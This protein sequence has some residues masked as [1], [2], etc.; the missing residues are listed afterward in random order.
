MTAHTATADPFEGTPY[1]GVKVIGRGGMG[2][3]WKA[4][5]RTLGHFVVAKFMHDRLAANEQAVER[6]RLEAQALAQI[7]HPNVVRVLDYGITAAGAPY[8]AME[9]LDGQPLNKEAFKRVAMPWR[10]AADITLQSLAGLAAAHECGVIH[11]D[12]KPGNIFYCAP[13]NGRRVVKVLDFGI[14]KVV[15]EEASRAKPIAHPTKTGTVL[16]TPKYMAPEQ[17]GGKVDERTD[18]YAI[19]MIFYE[20]LAG[21]GPFDD[22]VNVNQLVMKQMVQVPDPPSDYSPEDIPNALDAVVLK[23]LE[24]RPEDRFSSAA[25][26]AESIASLLRH[27]PVSSPEVAAASPPEPHYDSTAA[28][29]PLDAPVRPKK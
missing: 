20:L 10:E 22:A 23:A 24:K 12:I 17:I 4:Q 29:T 8:Y 2:E 15:D 7:V 5:H 14:A 25:E 16:G 27:S 1:V 9:L 19:G 21:R 26:F 3:A 13:D 6:M 18:L 28:T 11:R